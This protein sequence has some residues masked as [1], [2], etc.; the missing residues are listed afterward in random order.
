MSLTNL[1][2]LLAP[3]EED[4]SLKSRE[5]YFYLQ[6]CDT[7]INTFVGE[8]AIKMNGVVVLHLNNSKK[9]C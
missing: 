8:I 6:Y 4:K 1:L 2:K 5:N 3:G 9:L 7:V